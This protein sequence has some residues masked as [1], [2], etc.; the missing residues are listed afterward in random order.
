MSEGDLLKDQRGSP[1]YISPDVLSG[2]CRVPGS[3]PWDLTQPGSAAVHS[4]NKLSMGVPRARCWGFIG[5]PNQYCPSRYK[6]WGPMEEEDGNHY[7]SYSLRLVL[8]RKE[9]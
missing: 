8:G 9:T 1:A 2:M 3:R 6:I 7:T 5:G 4:V